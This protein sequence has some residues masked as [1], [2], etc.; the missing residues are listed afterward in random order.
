MLS[1]FTSPHNK[2]RFPV[3]AV[4]ADSIS[5][6][7]PPAISFPYTERILTALQVLVG[8]VYSLPFQFFVLFPQM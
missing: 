3:L 5:P 4:S 6:V 7:K 1:T 2:D 8:S